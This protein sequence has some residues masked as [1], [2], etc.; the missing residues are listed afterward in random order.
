MHGRGE[1]PARPYLLLLSYGNGGERL[2]LRA[3]GDRYPQSRYGVDGAHRENPL[4][5]PG[6]HRST[7]A[8]L[9]AGTGDPITTLPWVG[10]R[11]RRWEPEPIRWVGIRSGLR[12]AKWAD[13]ME[14]RTQR[15]SRLSAVGNWLRGKR[16]K[17][18]A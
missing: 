18:Q 4:P 17:I 14:E 2:G 10:H 15:P 16:A 5:D 12:L 1:S 3:A 9:V 7:L 11:S 6:G 13:R 8:H